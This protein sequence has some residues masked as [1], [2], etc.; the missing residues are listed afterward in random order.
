MSEDRSTPLSLIPEAIHRLQFSEFQK[1]Y[2]RPLIF[3]RRSL[4]GRDAF[5]A[6]EQTRPRA[7]RR[8]SHPHPIKSHKFLRVTVEAFRRWLKNGCRP[9]GMTGL[10]HRC[11]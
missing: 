11:R 3:T 8:M 10:C 7:G 4:N 2:A 9:V 5:Y 6:G 1:P